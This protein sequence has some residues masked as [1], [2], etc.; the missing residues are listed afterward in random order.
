MSRGFPSMT[1]LLGLLAI[2]GYQNRDKIAEMLRGA[3]Q[4][5][6]GTNEQ[7]GI[8]GFLGQLVSGAPAPEE[9]SVVGWANSWSNSSRPVRAK[10][11]NLGSTPGPTNRA[12]L[13]NLSGRL[14]PKC[15]KRCRGKRACP[16]TSWSQD[17]A[18][19]SPMQLIS[20][21]HKA[22][23]RRKPRFRAH[24]ERWATVAIKQKLSSVA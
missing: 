5:K 17:F 15:W 23:S 19:N 7:G 20:T 9:F 4:N 10:P 8:G 14:V 2:A 1:A 21:R 12:R 18:A 22:G 11:Q 13:R 24:G 16:A 6:P 3:G